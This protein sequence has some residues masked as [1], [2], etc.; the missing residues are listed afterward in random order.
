[1]ADDPVTD[2]LVDRIRVETLEILEYQNRWTGGRVHFDARRVISNDCIRE[3]VH[4]VQRDLERLERDHDDGLSITK[5]LGYVGF[6]FAKLKPIRLVT[7]DPVPGTQG[8]AQQVLDIN[9]Q[10]AIILMDRLLW[11]MVRESPK[12]RPVEWRSCKIERCVHKTGGDQMK[13]LCYFKKSREYCSYDEA[14]YRDYIV[15]ALRHRAEGP[16][17]LVKYLDQALFFSCEWTS[18]PMFAKPASAS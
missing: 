17:F 4:Y 2:E 10:V 16:Y 12:D 1:L 8:R 11:I 15:Y 14:K 3:V 5:Y 18:P 13:G 6:W 9:E 7:L